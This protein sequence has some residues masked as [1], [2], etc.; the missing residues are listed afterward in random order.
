MD[1]AVE[2]VWAEISSEHDEVCHF[3]YSMEVEDE[4]FI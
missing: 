3:L 4:W 1:L 2:C